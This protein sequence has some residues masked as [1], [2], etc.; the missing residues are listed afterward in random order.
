MIMKNISGFTLIEL[1]VIIGLLGVLV[2]VGV[3]SFQ[4]LTEPSKVTSA[5]RELHA[6]LHVARSEAIRWNGFACVCPST[7]VSDANPSCSGTNNWE[8]G[9]IAFFDSN[10]TG[11]CVFDSGDRM[12]RSWDGLV[13]GQN[14]VVRNNNASI[15]TPR[16]VRFDGRGQ[17]I[18][19]GGAA[20]RGIFTICDAHGLQADA[21]GNATVARGV[22][23]HPTGRSRITK[24]A[25][26]L[27][28][29]V[30]P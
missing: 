20:Q 26:A 29:T 16:F 25:A 7:T 28:A 22:D 9:W 10:A 27:D 12:V 13:H 19:I 2:A 6:G 30:C 18:Q 23:I 3:P 15:N 1:M 21:S 11:T 5:A 24:F 14:I 8:T 4:Y 17:A